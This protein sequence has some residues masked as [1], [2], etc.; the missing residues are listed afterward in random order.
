MG[1]WI[2]GAL[3]PFSH[4]PLD[5]QA[6]K[7]Q[8]LMSD[9]RQFLPRPKTLVVDHYAR[10][11]LLSNRPFDPATLRHELEIDLKSGVADGAAVW[12]MPLAIGDIDTQ[13]GIFSQHRLLP[14]KPKREQSPPPAELL[15]YFP[16]SK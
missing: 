15:T 2:D 9:A 1:D 14:A 12:S 16:H 8:R 7:Y 5:F 11:G 4:R 13:S 6:T 10:N 3:C